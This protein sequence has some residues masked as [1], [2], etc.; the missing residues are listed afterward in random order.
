[1]PKYETAPGVWRL[2][3]QAG[4][5]PITKKYRQKVQTFRGTAK[6]A[7]TALAA[8]VTEARKQQKPATRGT[9]GFVLDAFMVDRRERKGLA[10]KTLWRYEQIVVD[11]KVSL[12]D[13]RL[14]KLTVEDVDTAYRYIAK[15]RKQ[16]KGPKNVQ[17][18]HAVLRAALNFAV[19]NGWVQHNMAAR[20]TAPAWDKREINPPSPEQVGKLIAAAEEYDD[21]AAVFFRLAADTGARPGELCALRV[22]DLDPTDHVIT[23]GR[24]VYA[25]P[26]QQAKEK[27]TKTK[28]TR[29]VPI[30]EATAKILLDHLVAMGERAQ[31]GRTP[32]ADDFFIFSYDLSGRRPVTPQLMGDRFDVCRKKAGLAKGQRLYDLRHFFATQ[33]LAAGV[34]VVTVSYLL[35]HASVTMTLNT[36]AHYLPAKGRE[37]VD[38][39]ERLKAGWAK[40]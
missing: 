29:R 27:R 28:R 34:D 24:S 33:Q 31:S 38:L 16:G 20:T 37:T 32:L 19:R 17:Q 1:M 4:Q 8:L 36:Y 13:T 12:G 21:L 6:Q 26:G 35:G 10:E 11:L 39:M 23:I 40:P 9:I 14:D 22:S 15:H 18:H 30:G 3:A 5:D 2:V 25:L 7:D